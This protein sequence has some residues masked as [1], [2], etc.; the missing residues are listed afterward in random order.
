MKKENLST[1]L[2]FIFTLLLKR[3]N[4]LLDGVGYIDIL[5]KQPLL[6]TKIADNKIRVAPDQLWVITVL[7]LESNQV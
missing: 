2:T 7:L 6:W 3:D 5:S 4:L 1:A